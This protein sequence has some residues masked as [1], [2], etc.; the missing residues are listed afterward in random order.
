[1]ALFVAL[2][3]VLGSFGA[4]V[5]GSRRS[6]GS[7]ARFAAGSNSFPRPLVGHEMGQEREAIQDGIHASL[8]PFRADR[9]AYFPTSRIVKEGGT[10]RA[11][12]RR[13]PGLRSYWRLLGAAVATTEAIARA[14]AIV[15]FDD[16]VSARARSVGQEGG[17]AVGLE[18]DRLPEVESDLEV[19]PFLDGP[20]GRQARHEAVWAQ[21]EG[22]E[23]FVAIKLQHSHL[24]LED[25]RVRRCRGDAAFVEGDGLGP[26]S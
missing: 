13:M 9:L 17:S 24:S 4:D 8:C 11:D 25:R 22:G 7:F 5:R 6:L 20:T 12:D 3:P 15:T 10:R 1:M 23:D 2:A 19:L 18:P 21:G 14:V 16:K 26:D